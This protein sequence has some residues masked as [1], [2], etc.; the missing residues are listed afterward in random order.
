MLKN[1]EFSARVRVICYWIVGLGLFDMA[2]AWGN[3][4]WIVQ[5]L[6]MFAGVVVCWYMIPLSCRAAQVLPRN[7]TPWTSLAIGGVTGL[8]V[9]VLTLGAP[10]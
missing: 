1:A 7:P 10:L 9:F 4:P 2:T 5:F 6:R 8:Q 3:L